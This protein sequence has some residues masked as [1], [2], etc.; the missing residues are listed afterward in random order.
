MFLNV[1]F[2]QVTYVT[3]AQIGWSNMQTISYNVQKLGQGSFNYRRLGNWGFGCW[4]IAHSVLEQM[5]TIAD[6]YVGSLPAAV[7]LDFFW[8]WHPI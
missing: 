5:Q 8:I 1:L 3:L 4:H 7:S 2:S 6:E